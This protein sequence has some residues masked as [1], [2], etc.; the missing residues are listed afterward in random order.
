MIHVLFGIH[1]VLKWHCN[2]KKIIMTLNFKAINKTLWMIKVLQ[3]QIFFEE[4]R[5][6]LGVKRNEK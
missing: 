2:L 1:S 6:N 4:K 3:K 5:D